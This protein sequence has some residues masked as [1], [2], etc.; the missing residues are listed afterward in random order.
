ML[1][2]MVETVRRTL[3]S[4]SGRIVFINWGIPRRPVVCPRQPIQVQT[5]LQQQNLLCRA[6]VL[7]QKLLMIAKASV[8]PRIKTCLQCRQVL[9][10]GNTLVLAIIRSFWGIGVWIHRVSQNII[11]VHRVLHNVIHY[12]SVSLYNIIYIIILNVLL[13]NLIVVKFIYIRLKKSLY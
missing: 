4:R 1:R 2:V 5:T 10:R 13:I 11:R 9:I 12:V 3:I 6:T 7:P 8:F